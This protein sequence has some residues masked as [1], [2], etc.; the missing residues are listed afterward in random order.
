VQSDLFAVGAM[1]YEMLTGERVRARTE[2]RPRRAPSAAHR[3]LDARHDDVVLRLLA[4]EPSARP[5]DAFETRHALLALP[6]PDALEPAAPSPASARAPSVRPEAGRADLAPDGT[7]FDRWIE[8]RFAHAPLDARSLARASAFARAGHP[9]LQYVLRIDRDTA[10]IWLE[11]TRGRPLDA[12]LTRAQA[13]SLE[14]ALAALHAL[15]VAHGHV[16][17]AHVIIDDEGATTLAFAPDCS[18]TATI[19]LDRLAL[20]RLESAFT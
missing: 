14:G 4:Q 10:T 9:A 15:G 18:P 19:D 8:R 3:D 17:R 16:D 12:P 5:A 20:A 1:L 11:P 7:G 6:W 13:R 2:E